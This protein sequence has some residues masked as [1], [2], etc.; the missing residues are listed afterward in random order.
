MKKIATILGATALLA[1][2]AGSAFAANAIRISQTYGGGG[3]TTATATFNQDYVELFNSSGAAVNIGGWEVEYAGSASTSTF[4]GGGGTNTYSTY[5]QFPA[6]TMI[7]PCSYLLVGGFVG[8]AAPALTPTPDFQASNL[9][10]FPGGVLNM[11]ATGGCVGLFTSHY[12]G[13]K[14]CN[15]GSLAG[16]VDLVQCGGTTCGEGSSSA[17]ATGLN[18]ADFR[19]NGGMIDTDINSADFTAA[20][21]APRNSLSARNAS[22]LAT[23]TIKSTWGQLKSIY[24]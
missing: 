21:P 13:A 10:L 18:L 8:S 15:A 2:V 19:G 4:G 24:R 1:L 23:P 17:P 7:Q 5:Y 20:T 9:T 16:V 3:T 11:T 14:A 6:G 22:C 12:A